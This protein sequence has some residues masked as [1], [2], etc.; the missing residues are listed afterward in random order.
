MPAPNLIP[1]PGFTD[2]FSSIS[3]LLGAACF[4]FLGAILVLKG[5][6]A[7]RLAGTSPAAHALPLAIFA[8]AA[9][10]LLSMSGTFHMLQHGRAR[11]VLQRLDHAAIF[12][13]IAATFTPIHSILFR[14]R[15]R[16]GM[17]TLIWTCAA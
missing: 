14:G 13:L 11:D 9:I 1:I 2:P 3:H 5:R 6:R 8:L 12:V 16:W 4:A 17:L 15:W 10:I 7:A